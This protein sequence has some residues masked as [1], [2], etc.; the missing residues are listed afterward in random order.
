MSNQ[1]IVRVQAANF[2]NI[3]ALDV[4]PNRYLTKISGANGA[5]KTSALDAIFY[6]LL[7]RKTLPK[8]LIRQGQKKGAIFIETTTHLI[9]RQLDEKGGSLQIEVKATGN[10][11]KAPD[12]WLE[13]IAGRLG[14]DPL[15][16]MRL[17]PEEQFDALKA[18]VPLEAD[19]DDLELRNETDAETI[20]RRKA[21]AKRLEAARDHVTVDKTLP[22]ATIDINELLKQ[23]RE[24]ETFNQQIDRDRRSREDSAREREQ[25]GRSIEDRNSRL[26]RLR[27]EITRMEAGNSQNIDRLQAIEDEE[28]KWKPLPEPLDRSAIDARISEANSTNQAIVTNNANRAQRDKHEADVDTISSEL[29]TLEE[30]V[31]TRKL[32]IAKALDNAKFPVAGLSFETQSEGSGGRERK[33][34][35]KVITYNG[36][37][38]SEASTAEQIRVSTAIG[39]AGKPELRFLLIREGSLL[40]DSNMSVLEEMAHQ[41]DFQIV[42]EVVDTTGRVGIYMEEGEVK[43]VN[44]EAEPAPIS[45]PAKEGKKPRASKKR[46][47]V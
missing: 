32:A 3:R 23:S 30:N 34:P 26:T 24:A 41:H 28:A 19:I 31:R 17:R 14:F 5:G 1:Q 27:E 15:K 13:G 21:E 42:L 25:L 38:L 16:F 2:K 12:D 44:T 47:E 36:V 4:T 46:A 39:M 20:T 10:L 35:K 22:T 18:L 29:K 40:D 9:T 37:P 33:N 11:L 8:E 45:I 43:T 7:G 6:G